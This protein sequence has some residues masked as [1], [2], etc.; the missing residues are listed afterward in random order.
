M[1]GFFADGREALLLDPT[2]SANF[3]ETGA[4][5]D[6][7]FH[8]RIARRRGQCPALQFPESR[9][10]QDRF[11]RDVIDR[12]VAT[13]PCTSARCGFTGKI[14]AGI[15]CTLRVRDGPSTNA[16]WIRR[17]ADHGD[18]ARSEQRI[19]SFGQPLHTVAAVPNTGD[20]RCVVLRQTRTYS[21]PPRTALST[22]AAV[23]S[24]AIS[25]KHPSTWRLLPSLTSMSTPPV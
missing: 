8:S 20:N 23:S 21:K 12:C 13:Q 4:E 2:G 25:K 19:E 11:A 16:R 6:Q 14:R 7:R 17:R 3:S 1:P 10:W 22:A 5:H 24:S 9:R 18:G 15:A